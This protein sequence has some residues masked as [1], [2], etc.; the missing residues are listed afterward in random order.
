MS[1]NLKAGL[2]FA[3]SQRKGILLSKVSVRFSLPKSQLKSP[4][5]EASFIDSKLLFIPYIFTRDPILDTGIPRPFRDI[6][7]I[8]NRIRAQFLPPY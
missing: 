7:Q 3:G 5:I 8:L 4:V 6:Y 1:I 2:R